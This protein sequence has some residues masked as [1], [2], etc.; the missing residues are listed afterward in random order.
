[1]AELTQLEDKLAEVMGLAQA[2]KETTSKV[3]KL[4]T[5][6][7]IKELLRRMREEADETVKRCEAVA[8]DRE[9]KKGAI[10]AKARETKSEAQEMR[11]AYLDDDSD[12][13]DGL[14]FLTM[15]EAGEVGHVAILG[16]MSEKAKDQKVQKLAKW[17]EPIQERH[18]RDVRAASLKLAKAEDPL[19]VSG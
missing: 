10:K 1:M 8:S 4:V 14:E 16:V 12:G 3:G 5:D 11:D 15:T 18:L 7:K 13:L 17:A 19:E 6:K 9:G 2:A